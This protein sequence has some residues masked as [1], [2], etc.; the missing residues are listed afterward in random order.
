MPPQFSS[1]L[2]K[3]KK[4]HR[5]LLLVATVLIG[6]GQYQEILTQMLVDAQTS[7]NHHTTKIIIHTQHIGGD[8][9]IANLG[10]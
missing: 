9:H 7:L 4:S 5:F 3:S 1:F 8:T 6:G 2:F 10:S